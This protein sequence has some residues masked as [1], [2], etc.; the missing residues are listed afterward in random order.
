MA[1][2]AEELKKIGLNGSEV[3]V[4]KYLLSNGISTPSAIG[5]G[6]GIARTNTYH[7]LNSLKEMKLVDKQERGK[8]FVYL[9]GNPS[10]TLRVLERRKQAMEDVLPE[11]VALYKN[12]KNKPVFQFFEGKDGLEDLY[13]QSTLAKEEIHAIGSTEKLEKAVP[14]LLKKYQI[15]IK[16]KGLIL[17]DLLEGSARG[18]TAKMLKE[19]GGSLYSSRFLP[20]DSEG[21]PTDILIWD[22][23]VALV[24]LEDPVFGTLI[25]NQ[26][27]ADTFR[28]LFKFA[29][30]ASAE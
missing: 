25:Q 18:K 12:Q 29:W 15:E 10:S 24:T 19:I 3:K 6:T 4:Y 26:H 2:I 21:I 22:D 9:A 17:T 27:L 11:L 14:G 8:R 1:H 13:M 23:K 7:I 16:K 5:K 28:A 30:K 20:N